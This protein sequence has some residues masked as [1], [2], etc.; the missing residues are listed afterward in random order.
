MVTKSKLTKKEVGILDKIAEAVSANETQ[1]K[2]HIVAR[3]INDFIEGLQWKEW[4][5]EKGIV[6]DIP[7]PRNKRRKKERVVSNFVYPLAKTQKA[8]VLH[9]MPKV[10][11]IPES[12]EDIY[13]VLG[14]EMGVRIVEYIHRRL[15][16]KKR[17]NKFGDIL[18]S[19]GGVVLH[20]F[21]EKDR[22][23]KNVLN[24]RFFP[25]T[26]FYPYPV[27]CDDVEDL[28]GAVWEREVSVDIM[29]A[30]YPE[31]DFIAQKKKEDYTG[32]AIG[33]ANKEKKRMVT[34]RDDWRKPF[35]KDKGHFVRTWED[36]IIDKEYIDEFPHDHGELPY[37]LVNENDRTEGIF[38][39]PS[40][41]LI[42]NRQVDFNKAES[43]LAELRKMIPKLLISYES[44]VNPKDM[45]DIMQT[46]IEFMGDTENARP[47]YTSIPQVS[48][49]LIQGA[50]TIPQQAEHT[51]GLHQTVMRAETIGSIQS[52]V[53]I[54]SLEEQD[55]RR[56]L[57]LYNNLACGYEAFYGQ[58]YK[59]IKQY[60]DPAKI[61]SILGDKGVFYYTAF[62]SIKLS[63]MTFEIEAKSIQPKSIAVEQERAVQAA[64][65]GAIDFSNPKEKRE[66][67]KIILPDRMAERFAPDI[68]E[69]KLAQAEN[70]RMLAGEKVN[71]NPFDND[72]IH[73]DEINTI[74]K[75]PIF[76]KFKN[77][78][79]EQMRVAAVFLAHRAM[80][81]KRMQEKFNKMM[82]FKQQMEGVPGQGQGGA[83]QPPVMPTPGAGTGGM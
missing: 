28:L 21:I 2:I 14:A 17:A 61:K 75:N 10:T 26:Q 6:K 60:Y 81:D 62:K 67:L 59:L 40:A 31:I 34:I 49:A 68:R 35:Y 74:I 56:Q 18:F 77:G 23:D 65:Y 13:D 16:M 66:F 37:I 29:K 4:D 79:K 83:G 33:E 50:S 11:A 48:P 45:I 69:E 30:M 9:S 5:I 52:G 44:K 8:I 15:L 55:L 82:K 24:A 43:L 39:F 22:K 19:Y 58:G 71:V 57:P 73:I 36:K 27:G 20:P 46:V 51:M 25:P 42:L 63:P 7:I 76:D 41:K 1:R 3:L 53:G 47:S 38:G 54:Q 12:A 70:I 80:H 72:Q 78:S 32:P 64:Q